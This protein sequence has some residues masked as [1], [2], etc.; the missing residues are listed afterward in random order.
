ME[1]W[2]SRVL[3]TSRKKLNAATSQPGRYFTMVG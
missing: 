2:G 1:P 3:T